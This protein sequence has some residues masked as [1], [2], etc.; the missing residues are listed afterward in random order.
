MLQDYL[1]DDRLR[2]AFKAA[3][4]LGIGPPPPVVLESI[5]REV[6]EPLQQYAKDLW[7]KYPEDRESIAGQVMDDLLLLLER[8]K[9]LGTAS[10]I[11]PTWVIVAVMIMNL[12]YMILR[13]LGVF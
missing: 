5:Q 4:A 10:P 7:S 1:T 2:A 11:D 3:A 13:D 8:V 6:R 9:G 12:L